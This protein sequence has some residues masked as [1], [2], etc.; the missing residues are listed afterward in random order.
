MSR[1]NEGQTG[2]QQGQGQQGGMGGGGATE[3]LRDT[4]SQVAGQV[5]DMA[6]QVRDSAREQYEHLRD[7]AGEYYDQGREKAQQ[8]QQGIEQYV[9]DQP[10]KALLIAAGVGVLLGVLWK[11]S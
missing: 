5:R 9:Q 4:A 6:G 8:W 3:Q 10:V 7:T 11:K 2:G 1:M